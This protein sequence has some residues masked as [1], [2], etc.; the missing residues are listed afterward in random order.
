MSQKSQIFC[1]TEYFWRNVPGKGW[2][3][4]FICFGRTTTSNCCVNRK[5]AGK[6]LPKI[7]NKVTTEVSMPAPL[8]HLYCKLLRRIIAIRV[9]PN[10]LS[11]PSS[12]IRRNLRGLSYFWIYYWV[13]NSAPFSPRIIRTHRQNSLLVW[14]EIQ[15]TLSWRRPLQRKSMDWF[16]YDNG[17]RHE[18]VK[19]FIVPTVLTL[20]ALCI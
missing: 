7:N 18:R 9:T 20:P 16:L 2:G 11:F 14:S 17:L 12:K 15:L 8:I 10:H 1:T 3:I 4:R 19:W 6:H 5:T 13:L